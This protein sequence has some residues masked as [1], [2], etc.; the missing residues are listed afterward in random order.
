MDKE[1]GGHG[2]C[3]K[4]LI[5]PNNMLQTQFKVQLLRAIIDREL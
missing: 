4:N 1:S 5:C 3:F 2:K